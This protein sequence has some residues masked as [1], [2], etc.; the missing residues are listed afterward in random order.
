MPALNPFTYAIIEDEPPARAAL[1]SLMG[2][3][4]P[5]SL[6]V[7]EASD[8]V[9]G[10]KLLQNLRPDLLFLDI[11]FPP[12]GAFGMLEE[13][14]AAGVFLPPIAFVTAYDRFALDAFRW[15]ACDYLLK[16][17]EPE[18]LRE[19]LRRVKRAPDFGVLL[20]ALRSVESQRVPERFTVSANG[21]LR[22]LRWQDVSSIQTENRLVFVRTAEGRF[23]LDRSLDELDSLLAPRFLRIHRSAM[24]NLAYVKTLLPDPGHMSRL[25]LLDGQQLPVSRDRLAHVRQALLG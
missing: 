18:Q 2:D 21:A 5:E 15:A 7:G 24:V 10:L 19:T 14:R 17:V 13:A 16:P 9:S 12:K 8:G 25:T 3:L 1:K 20:E 11:Q 4:A 6:C 23:I 22:V